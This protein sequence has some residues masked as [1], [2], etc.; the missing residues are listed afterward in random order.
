MWT[1]GFWRQFWRPPD[2]IRLSA[3]GLVCCTTT[4]RWWGRWT[5]NVWRRSRSSGRSGRIA[6]CLLFSMSSLWSPCSVGLGMR[7][8]IRP[9]VESPLPAV[10]GRRSLRTT[11]ISLSLCPTDRKYWLWRRRLRGTKKYQVPRSILI[12]AKV[13]GWV[14]GEVASS[15]QGPSAGAMDPSASSGCGLCRPPTGAKLVR[16]PGQ[17]RS[18]GGYLASKVPG[19]GALCR[20]SSW[21]FT[22]YP[23]FPSQRAL[24]QPLSK[25]LWKDR[26]PMVRGQVCNQ[27]SRN[28]G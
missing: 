18:V 3:N 9:C 23:Y 6:P 10:L 27:P 20:S 25:L 2:S 22:A 4:R 21:S 19:G 14:P 1:I 16:G 26:S 12:R 5:K 24:K 7:R 11:I 13:C 17:G 8:L 15:C 28:G